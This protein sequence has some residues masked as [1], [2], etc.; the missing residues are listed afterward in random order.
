MDSDLGLEP[1]LERAKSASARKLSF[2]KDFIQQEE[3][4]HR[5]DDDCYII[6]QKSSLSRLIGRLLCRA[7]SNPAV[8]SKV[9]DVKCGFSTKGTLCFNS[10]KNFFEED[11]CVT[12][13]EDQL[14]TQTSALTSMFE[15]S[16]HLEG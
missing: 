3:D 6:V 2:F 10:C 13:L 14:P 8:T 7:S 15:Q 11:F 12:E 16:L 9:S 4:A 1:E 5:E